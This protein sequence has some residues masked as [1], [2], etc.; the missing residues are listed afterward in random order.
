MGAQR[1]QVLLESVDH[2]AWIKPDE[3]FMDE[4][5]GTG[6][7]VQVDIMTLPCM[8]RVG[9]GRDNI[10]VQQVVVKGSMVGL[11]GERAQ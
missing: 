8:R 7:R 11:D 5:D 9:D 4:S 10:G 2:G 1:A 6:T 3:K